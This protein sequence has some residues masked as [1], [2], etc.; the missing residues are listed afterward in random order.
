VTIRLQQTFG[1]HAGRVREF[2]QT[3]IRI[4]RL[5]TN[6]VAFDPHADLDA[7]G[8]HAE[9]RK[10][11]RGYVLVDVGSRNGTLVNGQTVQTY[12]LRGGEEIEFG[13]GG[14]R[15]RVELPAGAV[16][17][18]AAIPPSRF[19]PDPHATGP[20]TPAHVPPTPPPLHPDTVRPPAPKSG[21]PIAPLPVTPAAVPADESAKSR[22]LMIAVVVLSVL[23]L[24]SL[25]LL[26]AAVAF[27]M[28]RS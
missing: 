5:P 9:I 24:G 3:V 16:A 2:D 10:E 7:S 22:R 28:M 26:S 27:V 21:A 20:A 19:P 18:P 1:A 13:T 14:P 15:I 12:A 11:A 4:G 23:L 8:N 25:C 6:D 17:A